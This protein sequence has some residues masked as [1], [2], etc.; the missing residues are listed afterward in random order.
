M[1]IVQ[2]TM[3]LY[4]TIYNVYCTMYIVQCTGILYSIH[5]AISTKI[6][7][8]V[9]NRSGIRIKGTVSRDRGQDEPI[10]Q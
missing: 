7:K 10:E 4:C 6:R 2:N 8:L 1:Y 9:Q 3:Y 5:I